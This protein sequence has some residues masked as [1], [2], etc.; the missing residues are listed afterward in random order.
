MPA[1]V[2]LQA[3][4]LAIVVATF[5]GRPGR[6]KPDFNRA[7]CAF[8]PIDWNSG[9]VLIQR[10]KQ[11][12]GGPPATENSQFFHELSKAQATFGRYGVFPPK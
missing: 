7:A 11:G 10:R 2:F 3:T 9:L 5:C 8:N 12:L 4:L 1:A 6:T